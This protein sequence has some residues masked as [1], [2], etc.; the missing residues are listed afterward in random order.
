MRASSGGVCLATAAEAKALL[1]ALTHAI[2]A[3]AVVTANVLL[4]ESVIGEVRVLHRMALRRFRRHHLTQTG[5]SSVKVA[6]FPGA[7]AV[8]PQSQLRVAAL[9]MWERWVQTDDWKKAVAN[10][11]GAF[12]SWVRASACVDY[13][14]LFRP[15]NSEARDGSMC[16]CVCVLLC[17]SRLTLA[18]R[19]GRRPG[20]WVASPKSW[21][22][23]TRIPAKWYGSKA[24][25]FSSEQF[26]VRR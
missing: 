23:R 9:C 11:L 8:A 26:F 14:N 25:R 6:Y 24:M 7:K 10:P 2:A 16:V 22:R 20:R 5:A 3:L 4:S 12:K 18:N 17:E 15:S 21:C 1:Q 19:C 13:E